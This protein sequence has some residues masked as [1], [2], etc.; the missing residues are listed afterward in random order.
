MIEFRRLFY[1]EVLPPPHRQMACWLVAEPGDLGP[2]LPGLPVILPV[3]KF[4]TGQVHCLRQPAAQL[5]N[6]ALH[7]G[8][9]W[10]A[11]K[12]ILQI[13]QQMRVA[14]LPAITTYRNASVIGGSEHVSSLPFN[15]CSS[16]YHP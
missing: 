15:P 14:I 9:V 13:A 5:T 16:V 12:F 2:N 6:H 8:V 7:F 10:E 4:F 3:T 1:E 11:Q